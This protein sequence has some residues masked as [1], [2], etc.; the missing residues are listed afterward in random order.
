MINL[1]VEE[2]KGKKITKIFGP[3]FQIYLLENEPRIYPKTI[4]YPE[5]FYWKKLYNSEIESIINNNILEL[6]DL[7]LE[8][9]QS[10]KA[11]YLFFSYS[12]RRSSIILVHVFPFA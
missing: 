8:S 5:A 4:S 9:K 6:V 1:N 2:V 10:Y 12:F 3:D 7:S 11:F